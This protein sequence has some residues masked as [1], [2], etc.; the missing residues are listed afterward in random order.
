MWVILR[1]S[2]EREAVSVG[3]RGAKLLGV[4]LGI[5]LFGACSR[6]YEYE[7]SANLNP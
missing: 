1:W 6:E 2:L 5:G 7:L 4:E 3:G